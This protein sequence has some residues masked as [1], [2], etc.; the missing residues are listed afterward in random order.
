MYNKETFCLRYYISFIPVGEYFYILKYVK[1]SL[2]TYCFFQ[3][4]YYLQFI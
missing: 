3:I 4:V 1:R 2:E